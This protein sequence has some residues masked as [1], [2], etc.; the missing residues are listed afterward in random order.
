VVDFSDIPAFISILQDGGFLDEADIN[1]D[2]VVNFS[3]ITFFIDLLV[4]L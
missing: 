4:A 1:R 3:D 2:G